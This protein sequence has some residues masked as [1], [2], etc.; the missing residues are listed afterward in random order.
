MS[1]VVSI[2]V[3]TFQCGACEATYQVELHV[4]TVK[5]CVCP[6]CDNASLQMVVGTE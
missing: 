1:E 6:K 3:V 5:M 2:Q 4:G